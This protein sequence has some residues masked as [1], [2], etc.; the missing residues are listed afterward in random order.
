MSRA[1][2][3]GLAA[4]CLATLAVAAPAATGIDV[5]LDRAAVAEAVRI[6][7]TSGRTA[8]SPFHDRYRIPIDDPVIREVEIVTEFRQVVLMTEE[9]EGLGDATWDVD[10]ARMAARSHRGRLDLILHLQ[11]SP[12]N[13]YQSMPAYSV[14]LYDRPGGAGTILPVGTTATPAYVGGQPAPPGTPILAGSVR[15]MFDADRLDPHGRYLAAILLDGREVRRVPLD[16]G[17]IR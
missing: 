11:F 2:A 16:L 1:A 17:S 14:A 15:A 5:G 8:F 3:L 4:A 13:T 9:R 7:R 12:Q 6:G 10:R